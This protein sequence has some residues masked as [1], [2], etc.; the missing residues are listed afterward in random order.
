M[1]G[2]HGVHSEHYGGLLWGQSLLSSHRLHNGYRPKSPCKLSKLLPFLSKQRRQR[3]AGTEES[4]CRQCPMG[5][6]PF[7]AM[8]TAWHPALNILGAGSEIPSTHTP[9][10]VSENVGPTGTQKQSQEQSGLAHSG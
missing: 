4:T 1:G 2:S 9:K 5:R 10:K 6:G 8:A 7:S 3:E